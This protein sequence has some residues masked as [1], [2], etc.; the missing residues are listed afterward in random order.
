MIGNIQYTVN[1][2]N[3]SHSMNIYNVKLDM[4]M[5]FTYTSKQIF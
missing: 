1:G 2:C 3:A 4:S 5:K